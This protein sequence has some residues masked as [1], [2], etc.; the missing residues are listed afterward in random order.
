MSRAFS[1][2]S[3]QYLQE[4]AAAVTAA[5]LTISCWFQTS[6]T[7]GVS[8]TLVSLGA[9]TDADVFQLFQWTT[10]L[11][12]W[13]DDG[14]GNNG[15]TGGG[16][17]SANTWT[18]GLVV[19]RSST[20]REVYVNGSSVGS[21]SNAVVPGAIDRLAVGRK[22]TSSPGDYHDGKIGEV[23]VWNSALSAGQIT[24]L[25]GGGSPMAG[26][27]LPT[28]LRYYRFKVDLN[29]SDESGNGATITNNGSTFDA[30]NPTVSD[31]PAASTTRRRR[32]TLSGV[33]R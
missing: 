5:P 9:S 2:G 16:S 13:I 21:S 19:V 1:S 12:L 8:R 17:I 20:D 25:A 33:G 31:P 11:Y 14:G 27:T 3:S 22:I 26:G 32:R 23:A 15:S 24:A 29:F 18:H 4:G 30:S 6:L 28:P 7:T 10:G